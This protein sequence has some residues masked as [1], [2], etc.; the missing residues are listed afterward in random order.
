MEAKTTVELKRIRSLEVT[1]GLLWDFLTTKLVPY[2]DLPKGAKLEWVERVHERRSTMFVFSHPSF[3]E[4][5]EGATIPAY[6]VSASFVINTSRP[7][8]DE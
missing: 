8:E 5:P 4:M 6:A 1:D 2:L 7:M 3:E